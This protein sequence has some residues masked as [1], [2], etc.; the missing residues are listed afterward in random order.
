MPNYAYK[1]RIYLNYEMKLNPVETPEF[2]VRFEK[3]KKMRDLVDFALPMAN[4]IGRDKI[5]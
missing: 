4:G 1:H 2:V 3:A 5:L